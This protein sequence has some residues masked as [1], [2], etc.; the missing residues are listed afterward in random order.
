MCMIA[1][2]PRCVHMAR[3]ASRLDSLARGGIAENPIRQ[4]GD[5]D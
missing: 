1:A 2:S 3:A 5:S 4:C